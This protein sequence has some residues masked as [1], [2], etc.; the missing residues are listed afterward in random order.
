MA[1]KLL[2]IIKSPQEGKRYRA[3]F[4]RD[5]KE[6]STD[7]GD[8]SMSN[9]TIHHDP[10]RRKRYLMRHREREDWK[11]P[12]SAGALSRWILWG[13]STSLRENITMYKKRFDL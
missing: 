1:L 4:S 9:Y 13:D 6:T 7:F 8:S 10:E 3:V 12:T 2:K 5:G 11:D